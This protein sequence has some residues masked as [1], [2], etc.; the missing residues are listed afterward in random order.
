MGVIYFEAN[1]Y[2]TRIE[3]FSWNRRKDA[4]SC[5]SLEHCHNVR[6]V[7]LHRLQIKPIG[8]DRVFRWIRKCEIFS[9]LCIEKDLFSLLD[10]SRGANHKY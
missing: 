10:M 6:W 7:M 2:R 9:V 5:I 4:A 3:S 8:A 1:P